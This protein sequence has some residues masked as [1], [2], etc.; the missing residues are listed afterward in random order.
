MSTLHLIFRATLLALATT[1]FFDKA[2][3]DPMQQAILQSGAQQATQACQTAPG[4]RLDLAQALPTECCKGHK[5]ICGCRAG[6]IVCCDG[7]VSADA[8][9]TCHSDWGVNN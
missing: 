7:S 8:N 1:F 4:Q 3:A 2:M 9:C 5:G 6:K